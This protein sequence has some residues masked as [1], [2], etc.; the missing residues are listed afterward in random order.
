MP[1]VQLKVLVCDDSILV[2]RQLRDLLEELDCKVIEAKNGLEGVELYRQESPHAVFLDIVMPVMDGLKA[3]QAIRNIDSHA[4]IIMVSSAAT[5]TY[6]KQA[7]QS[8]AYSFIQKPYTKEQISQVILA[9]R[10]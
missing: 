5:S 10:Q 3:L 1:D 9:I 8:G 4:K 2:R 6:V 7:L